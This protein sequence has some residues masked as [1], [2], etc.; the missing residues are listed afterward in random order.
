[1]KELLDGLTLLCL[2]IWICVGIRL[3]YSGCLIQMNGGTMNNDR[4]AINVDIKRVDNFTGTR[5]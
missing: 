4:S 5:P 3:V 2:L 1:M